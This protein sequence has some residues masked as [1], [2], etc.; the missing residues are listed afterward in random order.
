MKT[1]GIR[2]LSSV[3]IKNAAEH[4]EVLG[5]TSGRILAGVLIPLGS[6]A[7]E[8]IVDRNPDKIEQTDRQP[9]Y[10][11]IVAKSTDLEDLLREPFK[12]NQPLVK[13]VPIRGV[14]A[15]R[16]EEAA[17]SRDVLVITDRG[18]AVAFLV[19]V[20]PENF[21]RIRS[22]EQGQEKVLIATF[23]DSLLGR[24][25][26][27]SRQLPSTEG[28]RG[29]PSASEDSVA[30]AFGSDLQNQRAV[31]VKISPDSSE[32]ER[33]YLTGITTDFLSRPVCTP[34]QV[35]LEGFDTGRVVGATLNLIGRLRAD[36]KE[37]EVLSGIGVA[38]G[39][40]V[41]NGTVIYSP[42]S[43]W[44]Q[45]PVGS[46]LQEQLLRDAV[47][48]PVVVENDANALA[49]RE[50]RLHGITDDYVGLILLS[51]RGV[52][53]ACFANGKMIRG[54]SGMAG[55]LGHIPIERDIQGAPIKCRCGNPDCL[56]MA[57][58]PHRIVE[59]LK[60]THPE[61]QGNLDQVAAAID[62]GA[63]GTALDVFRRAG[64][65]LG[66]AVSTVVNILNPSTIVLYGPRVLLGSPRSFRGQDHAAVQGVTGVYM[67]AMTQA[68]TSHVFSTGADDCHFVVRNPEPGDDAAAGAA[69][70][71]Q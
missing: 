42:D 56:E 46:L 68:I 53:S 19:P 15:T 29:A 57:T 23:L 37:N 51:S 45:F 59:Q 31:G 8:Q 43:E 22:S 26:E 63:N 4:G 48:V 7:V 41:K 6:D 38:V 10:E 11:T 71:F 61:L 40:H 27:D 64:D 24:G 62:N 12:E 66:R 33:V 54:A 47:D 16:I 70:V 67:G 25:S 13:R 39:G 30:A 34:I 18:T 52:G 65:A 58:A 5:I 32:G 9:G 35:T 20:T 44:R 55:E 69:C 21:S 17:Q 28:P 50:R 36:L 1:I 14:S 60:R 49:V 3:L 2:D